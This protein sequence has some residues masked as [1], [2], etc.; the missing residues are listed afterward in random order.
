MFGSSEPNSTRVGVLSRKPRYRPASTR[1]KIGTM[2]P[3]YRAEAARARAGSRER[4]D[5]QFDVLRGPNA[6]V[7]RVVGQQIP[8]QWL[9]ALAQ[10]P[11]P[12]DRGGNRVLEPQ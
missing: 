9:P 2:K 11:R 10:Q 8:R 3:R 1:P 7:G 6:R 4:R 5:E 12:E